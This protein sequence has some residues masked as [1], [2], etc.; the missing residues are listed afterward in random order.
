M[1]AIYSGAMTPELSGAVHRVR[2]QL[3]DM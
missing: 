2:L 3:D 1:A